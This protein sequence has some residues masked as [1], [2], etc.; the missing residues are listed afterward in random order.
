VTQRF[1]DQP[2]TI[3]RTARGT[4]VTAIAQMVDRLPLAPRFSAPVPC[5]FIPATA[6]DR[7]AF[8][9][10]AGGPVIARVT[11]SAATPTTP[12]RCTTIT[13]RVRSH[14]PVHLLSGGRLLHGAGSLLGVTLVVAPGTPGPQPPTT[15]VK[16]TARLRFS[17]RSSGRATATAS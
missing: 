3:D 4:P 17:P 14:A 11:A 9:A 2:Q 15:S 6:V 5:P 1:G 10:R 12:S 8:R 16:V 13:L 7:F